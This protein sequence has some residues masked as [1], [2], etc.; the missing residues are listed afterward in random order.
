MLSKVDEILG[1]LGLLDCKQTRTV[2]LSGGQRKRLSIALELVNNP[3]IMFFDEPTR[4]D[5]TVSSFLLLLFLDF[6]LIR[7]DWKK[8]YKFV[9]IFIFSSDAFIFPHPKRH[10]WLFKEVVYIKCRTIS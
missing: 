5:S 3:P 6:F 7:T 9:Q 10:K 4:Q 8:N 1:T 2:S